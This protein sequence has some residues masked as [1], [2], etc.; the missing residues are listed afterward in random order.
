MADNVAKFTFVPLAKSF[1]CLES[2]DN[3]EYFLKW[4]IKNRLHAT[5][6]TFDQYFQPYEINNFALD[7]FKDA[8]VTAN[9]K[10][11]SESG[12][13]S[14]LGI[15][16]E[17]VEV[18]TV[19]CSI[20]SMTFFDKIMDG[21]VARENGD[22]KKCFDEFQQ[23]FTIS[24]NL[25]QMLLNEDSDVYCQYNEQEREEFL[26]LLFSHLCLG[27]RLCQFEDNV[28]P[29]M[30]VAKALYKDLISVQK[31]ADT[32]QLSIISDVFKVY[33]Y[34][35]MVQNQT[36]IFCHLFRLA[37]W[38]TFHLLSSVQ[39]CN[40]D[41]LSLAIFCSDLLLGQPFTCYLL[42]RPATWT[43]FHLLSS[44]Q[45]CSRNRPPPAASAF[46]E[47]VCCLHPPV[48]YVTTY[49]LTVSFMS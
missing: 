29:Y 39:T 14:C 44:V 35:C 11:T 1:S 7:F 28:Q 46:S 20:L 48:N 13:T 3:Q 33:C 6:F 27:G 22:I 23:D 16:A 18:K 9:I 2:K 25:R 42:F 32:K 30:D 12:S 45:T 15:K 5:M 38:T 24:D 47:L 31:N 4:S 19:P 36:Y 34:T 43:T 41:N 17:K 26:F 21:E 37:T 10:V 8:N 40:L 49:H